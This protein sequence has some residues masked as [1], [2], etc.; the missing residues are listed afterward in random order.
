ML[1]PEFNKPSSLIDNL[2]FQI[3]DWTSY[4]IRVKVNEDDDSD[5]EDEK[6]FI[7]KENRF[8]IRGYGVNENGNS[9][10][11]TVENFKP[12]F[13]FK[14]PDQ[15]WNRN[16]YLAF[17]SFIQSKIEKEYVKD[18]LIINECI[19]E[20]RKEFYGFT[21]NEPF[22]F[23]KIVFKSLSGFYAFKKVFINDYKPIVYKKKSIKMFKMMYETKITPL[24]R[25]FSY[26]EYKTVWMDKNCKKEILN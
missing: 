7:K 1:R 16:N 6:K 4:D 24:L 5:D 9:I 21:N 11:I 23:G 18:T 20:E 13:Y 3:I 12:Y 25:F 22:K 2:K 19:I 15:S 26:S 10:C 14:L 8:I 17:I